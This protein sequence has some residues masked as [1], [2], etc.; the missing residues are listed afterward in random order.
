MKSILKLQK[1]APS[2]ANSFPTSGLSL[3]LCGC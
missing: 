1:L 2:N 3:L